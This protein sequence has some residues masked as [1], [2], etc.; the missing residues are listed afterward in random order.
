[1]CLIIAIS[2]RRGN[3]GTTGSAQ[4]F[5]AVTKSEKA[6]DPVSHP[7]KND[8]VTVRR[9]RSFRIF[10]IWFKYEDTIVIRKDPVNADSQSP[11]A[12]RTIEASSGVETVPGL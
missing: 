10:R 12:Y 8:H 7:A 9:L 1:M 2:K 3:R 11:P 6:G 4:D 5:Q